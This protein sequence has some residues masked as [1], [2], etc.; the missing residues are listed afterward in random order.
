MDKGQYTIK[1]DQERGLVRVHAQGEFDLKSGN[2]L[3]TTAR[4]KA[5]EHQY[6]IL[7][8]VRESRAVVSL[9]DWYFLPRRLAAY[10]NEKTRTVRTAIVVAAGRQERVYRF[11]ENVTSNLGLKIRIF[12]HE[13]DALEWLGNFKEA[14][15]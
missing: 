9:G 3:I 14:E 15:Q 7:C 2:E 4:K 12:L 1:L 11:F 8:D 5:A 10:K 6:H 13:E